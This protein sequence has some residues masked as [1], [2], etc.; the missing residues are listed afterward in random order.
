[1]SAPV[2]GAPLE[3]F[4]GSGSTPAW[5]A[6]L[7][8]HIKGL[9]YTGHLLSFS[10][11]ETRTP[12]F[13]ALNPR[14]KV[15]TLRHGE[16]VLAESLAILAY[17]DRIAPSPPLFGQTAAAHGAIWRA[18]LD[19]EN[20]AGPAL[21]LLVRPLLFGAAPEVGSLEVAVPGVVDELDRVAA[22][23][24]D[25]AALVEGDL[26]AADLVWY[27]AVRTL[28][29][30]LTRPAA[31]A[32]NLGLWPLCARWPALRPWAARIEAIPGFEQTF[33][34]HW[35]EGTAPLGLHLA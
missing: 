12:A 9:P 22:A 30:A 24:H 18:C 7:A 27:C 8:L 13:L 17:L 1:M 26:S 21:S 29:R 11:R 34:P 14:G 23:V 20:V 2:E 28:E 25:K 6:L 15:P 33:P 32:H 31:E 19:Y 3:L 10:A 16:V 35:R 5:R 4:W